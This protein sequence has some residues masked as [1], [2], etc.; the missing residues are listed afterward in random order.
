MASDMLAVAQLALQVLLQG[1]KHARSSMVLKVL[2]HLC[3]SVAAHAAQCARCGPVLAHRLA[4]RHAGEV[5]MTDV[6]CW[7]LCALASGHACPM[8]STAAFFA[9]HSW[10]QCLWLV[11]LL[12]YPMYALPC[13]PAGWGLILVLMNSRCSRE[14]GLAAKRP[15]PQ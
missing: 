12:R 6:P 2:Q 9:R 10:P 11:S 7:V 8:L 1:P 5:L 3:R 15:Q 13:S 14:R 4:S